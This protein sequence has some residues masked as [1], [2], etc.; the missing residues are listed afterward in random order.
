MPVTPAVMAAMLPWQ[1]DVTLL[2]VTVVL[3]GSN[4]LDYEVSSGFEQLAGHM[5]SLCPA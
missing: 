5:F 3:V 1:P 4:Q 2:C